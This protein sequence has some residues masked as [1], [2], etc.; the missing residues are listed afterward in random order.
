MRF[1]DLDAVTVDAYGTLVSVVDC[2]PKLGAELV[3]R[4]IE[5]TSEQIAAAFAA[6]TVHYMRHS[7]EGRDEATLRRLR[8]DCAAVFLSAL[9]A[10]LNADEFAPAY[11]STLE[12]A[13]LPGALET[14]T[15]L[16]ARG[17]ELAV[18]AN[19]DYLLPLHLDRLG[20]V[21]LF[22]AVVTSAETG[23]PKPDPAIFLH[24]LGRVGVEPERA[25][26]VGDRPIDREGARAAGMAFSPAPLATAFAGWK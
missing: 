16:R 6:E 26:H 2:V 20:V 4:G 23:A 17:L 1:A 9:E 3:A 22:S 12:L 25:V 14:V 8:A 24:A 21:E 19:W 11:V 10:G 15:A 7:H 5:R 13:L 18:V